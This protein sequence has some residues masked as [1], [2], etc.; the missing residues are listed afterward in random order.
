V[1]DMRKWIVA[2]LALQLAA[3][4]AMAATPKPHS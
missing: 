2:G 4:A 1:T 3:G